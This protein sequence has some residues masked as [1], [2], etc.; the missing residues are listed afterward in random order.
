MHEEDEMAPRLAAN[1]IR[2]LGFDWP[3]YV[4]IEEYSVIEDGKVDL[5]RT[6]EGLQSSRAFYQ[7]QLN[8]AFAFKMQTGANYSDFTDRFDDYARTHRD[9]GVAISYIDEIIEAAPGLVA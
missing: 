1:D 3:K 4:L 5:T 7:K 9:L 2:G 8:D 6:I